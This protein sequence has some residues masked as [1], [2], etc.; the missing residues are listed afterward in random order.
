MIRV[1][2]AF[3]GAAVA[4]AVVAA[5]SVAGIAGPAGAAPRVAADCNDSSEADFNGD[6]YDDAVIAD[7]DATVDS[8]ARAGQ[9][10]VLYG[11]AGGLVGQGG[12]RQVLRQGMAGVGQVAE[13]NDRFG[14]RVIAARVDE[15]LCMDLVIAAPYENLG[16]ATDAGVVHVLFGSPTGLG[17]ET[18]LI[19]QQG[20]FGIPG[21]PESGDRFGFSIALE[22]PEGPDG[23]VVAAGV[24]GEDIGSLSNAGVVNVVFVSGFS[25]F[26]GIAISQNTP[27][28]PGVAEA[29]DQFG[30]AVAVGFLR[31]YTDF[32]DLIAGAPTEDVGSIDSAGAI[33]VV[34]DIEPFKSSF[35]AKAVSQDT[36][37]VPGGAEKGDRFGYSLAYGQV[38]TPGTGTLAVGVPYENVGSITDAGMLQLFSNGVSPGAGI[39]QNSPGIL[40]AA[41]S[42]DQFGKVLAAAAPSITGGGVHVVV[43]IPLENI[44]SVVD[45][46]AVQ[47]LPASS[48]SADVAYDQNSAGV[49]GVPQTGDNFGR[50]VD[51]AGGTAE[52]ALLVGAPFD[53]SYSN[54]AVHVLPYGGGSPRLWIPGSG[55]ISGTGATS[56]GA[57]VSG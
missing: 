49:A 15:D 5:V 32:P 46:G 48:P 7:P 25:A 54:G 43:G 8:Q 37:G 2:S 44:G 10:H 30:Y 35:T 56:F 4:G 38:S 36:A 3:A 47:V 20:S 17:V 34:D 12:S 24:P 27:G 14:F 6:G 53:V 45:A 19:L 29:N 50:D 57:A 41:E 28:V 16:S 22:A 42:G 31:G 21:T 51:S 33:T 40:G 52:G 18:P 13:T 55:G 1:L 9:V 11:G 39:S 26:Q 23:T